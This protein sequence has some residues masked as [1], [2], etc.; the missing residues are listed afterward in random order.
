MY[1]EVEEYLSSIK[2]YRIKFSFFVG[3]E[4]L[5]INYWKEKFKDGYSA[6]TLK[7]EDYYPDEIH[8]GASKVD[9]ISSLSAGMIMRIYG[10]FEYHIILLCEVVQRAL[11]IGISHKQR[12]QRYG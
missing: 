11:D 2:Q 7:H 6:R 8:L 3:E 5:L 12:K 10:N 4:R 1:I 9:I